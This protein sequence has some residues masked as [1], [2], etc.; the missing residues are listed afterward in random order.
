M[1]H[2]EATTTIV[3]LRLRFLTCCSMIRIV[4][5]ISRFVQSDMSFVVGISSQIAW[6]E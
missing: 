3:A 1:C 2:S 6:D 5:D 4:A